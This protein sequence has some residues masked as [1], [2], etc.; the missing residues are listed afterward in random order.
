MVASNKFREDLLFRLNVFPIDVPNLSQRHEDIPEIIEHFIEK[1]RSKTGSSFRPIFDEKALDVLQNYDWPGNIREVR[2]I[3]ERAIVFFPKTKISDEDV[4]KYL[5]RIDSDVVI[6]TEE[7]DAIWSELDELGKHMLSSE[8]TVVDADPPSPQDFSKWFE[9]NNSVDLR[10]LL[11]DI[12]IVLIEA[13]M[14]RNGGN[15]SEAAK[16]LKLIRTTL[17]EKIRKYGI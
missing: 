2:N 15:T 7:Q 10:S 3:V 5:L 17:I 13:A 1:K 14:S 6:R 9:R 4:K 11:R 8:K 16:D 12:E